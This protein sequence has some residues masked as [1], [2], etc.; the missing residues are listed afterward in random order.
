MSCIS[1]YPFRWPLALVIACLACV[2]PARSQECGERIAPYAVSS[3]GNTVETGIYAI[4]SITGQPAIVS[5][6][7][8]GTYLIESGFAFTSDADGPL[9]CLGVPEDDCNSNGI[10]DECDVVA[11]LSEDCNSNCFPDECDIIGANFESITI[12][13]P[14][15]LD[16]NAATDGLGD[17]SPQIESDGAGKW[18]SVWSGESGIGSDYDIY[19][20]SSLNNGATWTVAEPLNSNHATD[21]RNDVSPQLATDGAG[22][23]VAVWVTDDDLGGTIGTDEDIIVARSA[24]NGETWSSVT[25]L[26]STAAIDASNIDDRAPQIA[27]D[28]NG[29]WIAVWFSSDDVGGTIGND[30]D[31][32]YAMSS[33]N[34]AS[35]SAPAPL[36]STAA[37][38]SGTD[39]FPRIA[40]DAQGT[41]MAVWTSGEDVGGAIGSDLDIL[42]CTSNDNGMTWSL[43]IALN[44]NANIDSGF[45]S[46]AQIATDG[47]GNWTAVWWSSDSLGGAID[48]DSDI[49]SSNSADNGV[50]WSLPSALND[51]AALDSANDVLPTIDTDRRGNWV[52]AWQSRYDMAGTIGIDDDIV[53]T[54]SNDAGHTWAEAAPLNLN[55]G[56][57]ARPDDSVSVAVDGRG[58]W[59]SVW[60]S[61]D[62]L[63]GTIEFDPDIIYSKFHIPPA[64]ADVNSNGV[65]DECEDDCNLNGIPDDIDIAAGTS[66]DCNFSALPD[67]CELTGNDCDTNGIPD[68]CDTDCNTNGTPDA[69]EAFTDCNTNAVPDECESDTDTDGFIDACDNCPVDAN[70]DQADFDGD[71]EGDTCDSDIDSDGVDNASDVCDFTPPGAPVQA[72]GGLRADADGDCDVDLVDFAILQFEF[73]GPGS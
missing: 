45:D 51:Y 2:G 53:F 62:D 61:Q 21:L 37:T 35:W 17:S 18:L 41:W 8:A 3:G 13:Y 46:D 1:P 7:A 42:Y 25:A 55:A 4:T 47:R 72:D 12:S 64:S 15:S 11:G 30:F 50:T 52:A 67:E 63:G 44:G 70:P 26:N 60:R 56:V 43:P 20:A 22:H 58:N 66:E 23:W 32:L 48:G 69:C 19:F 34:G 10:P 5:D 14:A 73:T 40:T 39:V 57:D 33:D 9:F 29:N 36:N 68:E 27:T 54:Y 59:L 65:P 6:I 71:G 38:D 24:D 49:L 31:I 28:G 16:L